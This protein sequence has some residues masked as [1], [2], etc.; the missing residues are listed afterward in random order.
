MQASARGCVH[1]QQPGAAHAG[2]SR[3][4]HTGTN[5]E[6]CTQAAGCGTRG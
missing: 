3:V 1:G 6:L 2:S 5:R 4:V